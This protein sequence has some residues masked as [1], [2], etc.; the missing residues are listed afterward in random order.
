MKFW[1]DIQLLGIC[2]IGNQLGKTKP[3]VSGVLL[4]ILVLGYV[5]KHNDQASQQ[6]VIQ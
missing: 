6:G 5:Q 3:N 1:H 4:G 2:L